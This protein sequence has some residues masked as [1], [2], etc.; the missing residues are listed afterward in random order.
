MIEFSAVIYLTLELNLSYTYIAILD[1]FDFQ[2]LK[3]RLKIKVGVGKA[4]CLVNLKINSY[5][6]VFQDEGN[7]ESE[8]E[9]FH[10]LE[11]Y[12]CLIPCTYGIVYS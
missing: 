4:V 3:V 5:P 8:S 6:I 11:M 1:Q 12:K 2:C 9:K 7:D 10:F